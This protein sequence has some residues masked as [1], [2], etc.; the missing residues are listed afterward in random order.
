ML[1]TYRK[2]KCQTASGQCALQTFCNPTLCLVSLK[3]CVLLHCDEGR[4]GIKFCSGSPG[5]LS[6][7][8]NSQSRHNVTHGPQTMRKLHVWHISIDYCTR[9]HGRVHIHLSSPPFYRLHKT[10]TFIQNSTNSW[11]L[12]YKTRTFQLPCLN[13]AVALKFLEHYSVPLIRLTVR[14]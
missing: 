2:K 13:L 5:N 14:R 7:S 12:F 6:C 9:S 11:G 3:V 1:V 8:G 10:Q 4:Y